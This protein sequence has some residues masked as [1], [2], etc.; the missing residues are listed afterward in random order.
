[1]TVH[2]AKGLE[3][4]FVFVSK[5][6]IQNVTAGSELQLEDALRQFRMNPASVSFNAQ[7]RAEQDYIR[8]FYV[9]YSR[10]ECALIFLTT[11]DELGKQGLGFGGYGQQWFTQQTQQLS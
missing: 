2:Q 3:F 1:M 7:Q 10:A 6:G 9:A 4:P 11:A 5:L 8:F